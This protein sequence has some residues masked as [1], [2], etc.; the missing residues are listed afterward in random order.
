MDTPDENHT[1]L[2]KNFGFR[3]NWILKLAESPVCLLLRNMQMPQHSLL[4]EGGTFGLERL[5]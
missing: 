5:F 1:H 2:Q 4:H 3:L